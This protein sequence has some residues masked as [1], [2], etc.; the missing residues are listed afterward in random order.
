MRFECVSEDLRADEPILICR[1]SSEGAAS[2]ERDS[3]M[4][5]IGVMILFLCLLTGL[6]EGGLEGCGIEIATLDSCGFI[7]AVMEAG[8]ACMTM[9]AAW[10]RWD[11][12]FF[13]ALAFCCFRSAG[14]ESPLLSFLYNVE[15]KGA[16][17]SL[18]LQ[19]RQVVSPL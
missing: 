11:S 4:G 7:S 12:H 9:A 17:W 16:K 15:H 6:W 8:G 1:Q 13:N 19:Y 18:D 14:I 3:E 2:S 5:G 10:S